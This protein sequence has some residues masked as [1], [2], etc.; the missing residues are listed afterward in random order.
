MTDS[1]FRTCIA[2]TYALAF[3]GNLGMLIIP[4]PNPL[5][6]ETLTHGFRAT[7]LRN[8]CNLQVAVDGLPGEDVRFQPGR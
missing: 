4:T 6:T 7:M 1:N 8:M 2:D 5:T 3:D